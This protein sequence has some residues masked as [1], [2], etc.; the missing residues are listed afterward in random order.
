M[1]NYKH[2][3]KN[4]VLIQLSDGSSIFLYCCVKKKELLSELDIRSNIL[5]KNNLAVNEVIS[6]KDKALDSFKKLFLKV[7]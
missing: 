3:K 5:W 1:N 6:D 7:K 4:K 2:L